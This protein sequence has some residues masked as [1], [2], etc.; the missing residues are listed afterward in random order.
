MSISLVTNG[1]L[2]PIIRKQIVRPPDSGEGVVDPLPTTPCGVTGAPSNPPPATPQG[3][4]ANK[5]P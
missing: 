5:A 1:M 4:R 3:T 2:Y